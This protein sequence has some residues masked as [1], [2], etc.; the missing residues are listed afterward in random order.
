MLNIF[1]FNE[2]LYKHQDRET[3]RKEIIGNYGNYIAH[4]KKGKKLTKHK[5]LYIDPKTWRYVYD[6]K[7]ITKKEVEKNMKDTARKTGDEYT[8]NV[9]RK[10]AQEKQAVRNIVTKDLPKTSAGDIDYAKIEKVMLDTAEETKKTR[11]AMNL[12]KSVHEQEEANKKS[13]VAKE[14]QDKISNLLH[15]AFSV[16][17]NKDEATFANKAYQKAVEEIYGYGVENRRKAEN[18]TDPDMV[19]KI[20]RT[21]LSYI[22]KEDWDNFESA[23]NKKK[24]QEDNYRKAADAAKAE[25]E[26]RKKGIQHSEFSISDEEMEA[27][28]K[29]NGTTI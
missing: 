10:S 1:E 12:M 15:E 2:M 14:W 21:T 23:K 22:K 18:E 8:Y 11:D 28:M 9:V 4:A 5:Y 25:E 24:Q 7:P 17:E 29:R 3:E 27:F 16:A 26:R 19:E 20:Y 6:D 13:K